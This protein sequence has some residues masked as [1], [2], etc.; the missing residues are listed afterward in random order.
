ME[1]YC[2]AVRCLED[3]FD[4]LELN[5]ITRKYNEAVDELAKIASGQTTIPQTSSPVT[6]TNHLLI[7]GNQHKRAASRPNHR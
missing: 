7:M 3:R 6:A 2:K 1:A 4:V 5:H